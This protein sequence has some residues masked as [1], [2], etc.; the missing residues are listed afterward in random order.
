[1]LPGND[2]TRPGI[3]HR[4]DK[5]TSGVM[6][7]AKHARAQE[8]LAALFRALAAPRVPRGFGR[9]SDLFEP[10]DR[11]AARPRPAGSPALLAR[12]RA[13]APGDHRGGDRACLFRCGDRALHAGDRAHAPDPDARARAGAPDP[14]RS[15]LWRRRSALG[16]D[17]RVGVRAGPT[18]A[19]R[20]GAGLRPPD[21]R[22]FLKFFR[23][24]CRPSWSL[25]SRRLRGDAKGVARCS[26]WRGVL[27]LWS[28]ASRIA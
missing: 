28:M 12:R 2:A 1:M 16:A 26:S 27:P 17:P 19:A 10:T 14:R 3:V 13:R 11:D 25:W 7:V 15:P 9:H 8:G 22:I 4:L 21:P 20:G 23:R 18:R 24:R 5:D 6:V